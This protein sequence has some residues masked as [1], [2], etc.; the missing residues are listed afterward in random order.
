[1][2]VVGIVSVGLCALAI[3]GAL[4]FPDFLPGIF[5]A[6]TD[7]PATEQLVT[8]APT[9]EPTI[10]QE[11]ATESPATEPPPTARPTTP[12]TAPPATVD[13]SLRWH[14]VGQSVQRRDL[15]VATIGDPNGA[16]IVIVGSIQ[17]DQPNTR[18][19]VSRLID[20]LDARPRTIPPGVGFHMIPSINPDGLAAGTRRNANNV[21]LNRNW[22]SFDWTADP[23]QPGG[24]V[25]GAGGASPFSEPETR[26]LAD[27]LLALQRQ[28]ARVRVVLWHA[29]QRLNS[30][31]VYPGYTRDGLESRSAEIAR[32]FARATGYALKE[33]WAPYETTGELIA[34]CAEN[35][36]AAID[37]V[38]PRSLSGSEAGLLDTTISALLEVARFP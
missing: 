12:P 5:G 38:I 7:V 32:R 21:D 36:I 37:V 18:V 23:E 2:G 27:Y 6:P 26:Q 30:G 11:D 14:T 8:I 16:A 22:G 13:L 25:R 35:D 31:E 19:L 34:W 15:D 28:D 4:A 33:D 1:L 20:E 29:S 3:G 24:V 17:G 9:P 10:R